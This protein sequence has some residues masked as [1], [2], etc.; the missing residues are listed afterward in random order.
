MVKYKINLL[1]FPK[2]LVHKIAFPPKA[3]FQCLLFMSII[4]FIF[5]MSAAITKTLLIFDIIF[6]SLLGLTGIVMAYLWLGRIDNVCRNNI[7]IL[8]A[9]PTHLVAVF[10]IRKKYNWVK[11]YFLITAGL[12]ALLLA[13]YPWWTQRMNAGVIPLLIIILFR[14]YCLFQNRNHAEKAVIQR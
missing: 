1:G 14:S 13:G 2:S 4:L 9:L 5:R 7:N 12:A 6:F 3:L 11:Y 8:W 10:F